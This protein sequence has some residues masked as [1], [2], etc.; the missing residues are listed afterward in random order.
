MALSLWV[1][2]LLLLSGCERGRGRAEVYDVAKRGSC[3]CIKRI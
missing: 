2:F 3:S 1:Q